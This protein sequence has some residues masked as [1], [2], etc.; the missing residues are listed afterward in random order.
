MDQFDRARTVASV[1]LSAMVVATLRPA[2]VG[3][4]VRRAERLRWTGRRAE[5][6]PGAAHHDAGRHADRYGQLNSGFEHCG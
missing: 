3:R 2:A 1:A 6:H 4:S 5:R